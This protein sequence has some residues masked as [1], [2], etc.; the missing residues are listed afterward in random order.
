MGGCH[1]PAPQQV[2]VPAYWSPATADGRAVFQRLA[3]TV[4]APRIVVVNGSRS[5]PEVPY[6]PAWSDAVRTLNSAGTLPLGYV[7]TGYLGTDSGSGSSATRTDGPGGG[8]RTADAWI[9]QIEND[10]DTWYSLYGTDGLRGIFLD[11]T[12]ALCG[13]GNSYV[14]R[15]R[16]IAE[17]VRR[18]HAGA[19]VVMNPGRSIEQCYRQIADTFVTFEGSYHDYL[20]RA[21]PSWEATAPAGTFWH[22]VYAAPDQASMARAVALSKQRNA[23][24]VYVIDRPIPPGGHA[25]LWDTIPPDGYWRA[26]IA[27]VSGRTPNARRHA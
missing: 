15:Y 11:Q 26:E 18:G 3:Q 21:A 20:S 13:P 25:H 23:G 16:A 24:Y 10:I 17:H 27:A 22:L 1:G 7:D 6:N 4:P 2:G 5:A 9:E 12:T 8:R 14:D 19:Y